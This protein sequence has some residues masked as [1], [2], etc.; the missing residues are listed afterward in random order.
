MV[1]LTSLPALSAGAATTIKSNKPYAAGSAVEAL[2]YAAR[3]D[4]DRQGFDR[5]QC[6]Q[7]F[8]SMLD[9]DPAA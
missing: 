9:D 5:Y 1:G 6:G 4:E 2:E 7:Q 8:A 3:L